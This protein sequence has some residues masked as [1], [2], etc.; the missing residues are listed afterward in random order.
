MPPQCQPEWPLWQGSDRKASRCKS[1]ASSHSKG[2]AVCSLILSCVARPWVTLSVWFS[3]KLEHRLFKPWSVSQDGP[4]THTVYV[5]ASWAT[6][7]HLDTYNHAARVQVSYFLIFVKL[8]GKGTSRFVL[9]KREKTGE[10][11][12]KIRVRVTLVLLQQD[13]IEYKT[14]IPGWHK[15]NMTK[16]EATLY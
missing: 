8:S 13:K 1:N 6:P 3:E 10:K 7:A 11:K 9:L 15:V 4:P 5:S 2:L 14:H 12:K 16:W